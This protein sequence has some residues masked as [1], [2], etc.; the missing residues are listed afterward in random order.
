MSTTIERNGIAV[1]LSAAEGLDARLDE[2]SHAP[3]FL[4]AA[5]FKAVGLS[6]ERLAY[7]RWRDRHAAEEA[8]D[9]G[10]TATLRATPVEAV[11][12]RLK[13]APDNT[14]GTLPLDTPG[15][16]AL[17][18]RMAVDPKRSDEL[19]DNLRSFTDQFL[20][21]FVPI[22]AVA[23]HQSQ[24]RA[25]IIE[26]LQVTGALGLGRLQLKRQLRRHRRRVEH[27]ARSETHDLMRL[28]RTVSPASG[29]Q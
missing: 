2:L 20:P 16:V 28:E 1:L 18:V 23:F 12:V 19:F 21:V 3:G 9:S 17:I 14:Y 11:S 27:I 4:G 5:V 26:V 29:D 24:D 6:G 25:L 22:R 15:M 13:A 10:D 8:L 7:T